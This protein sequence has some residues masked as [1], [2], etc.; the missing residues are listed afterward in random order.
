VPRGGVITPHLAIRRANDK[1]SLLE[2]RSSHILRDLAAGPGKNRM[3]L[4]RDLRAA[5]TEISPEPRIVCRCVEEFTFFQKK[6]DPSHQLEAL[7]MSLISHVLS[8]CV[9]L[10][11]CIHR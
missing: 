7:H 5:F 1:C 6:S 4:P 11:R 9:A 2:R 3:N 8:A 10:T